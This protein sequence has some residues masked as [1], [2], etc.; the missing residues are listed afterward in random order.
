MK[1]RIKALIKEMTLEEK[2]NLTVGSSG[3]TTAAIERLNIPSIFMSD[4]PHGLGKMIDDDEFYTET[5]KATCFPTASCLASSWNIDLMYNIGEALGLECQA[6]NVDILLGPGVNMK[7]SPLGG[8]N[9]EYFSEDPILAG[10][11]GAAFVNGVQSQ[12]VGTSVKHYACNNQ[13]FER[14]SI[15]VEVNERAL[16][17]IYLKA[18]EIIV[19][20]AQPW[21]I[22][23]AYNRLAGDHCTQ[24]KKLLTEILK[25]EWKY[26][27]VV[28]SD[29]GAVKDKIQSVKSGTGLEMP[30]KSTSAE[31][32]LKGVKN[33]LIKEEEIDNSLEELLNIIFKAVSHRKEN[34]SF[35]KELHHELAKKAAAESIVLLKNKNNILPL[36]KNKVKSIAVIGELANEPRYQGAGSSKV[37]A[38]K[39]ETPLKE[40]SRICGDKVQCKYVK[41]YDINDDKINEQLIS[42]AKEA[43]KT[44][45]IALLFVGMPENF[46]SEG[47]DRSHMSLPKSHEQLINEISAVSENIIVILQ[48]GSAITMP[49]INKAKGILESYLAGQAGG[50]AVAE[51]LFG[52]INP[53]GKLAES[54]PYKLSDNPSY[55]NFPGD[56][57][58]VHYG[59]GL[60]IGYRYYD[61]KQMKILYPFGYGLSY[62]DFEIKNI[63]VNTKIIKGEKLEVSVTVKNIGTRYGK[64]VIQ[65]YISDRLCSFD[66]PIKELKGFKKTDLHPNEEKEVKFI[67]E[68]DSFSYYNPVVKD[69]VVESGEFDILIGNSS[70]NISCKETVTVQG[71]KVYKKN[72]DK[73]TLIKLW[74]EEK[75]AKE[76]IYKLCEYIPFIKDEA[77]KKGIGVIT[78]LQEIMESFSYAMFLE[79]PL[80][81]LKEYSN[82]KI[83]DEMLE[84]IFLYTR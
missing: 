82:G 71:T 65:L 39:V 66:R 68:E 36:D 35:D 45:E 75:Q 56:G 1:D 3:W 54:F 73:N 57:G 2:A 8:R 27:G 46:E 38:I 33:G 31:E 9:F 52:D 67:L 76:K 72:Y 61:K 70:N 47:Y 63:R 60:Y 22:M 43:A 83:T 10:E 5:V 59:E 48:N 24:N 23:A 79:Q 19:K 64:E 15:N 77:D 40:I 44:S 25:E 13:E 53:S 17:E 50:S 84:S 51:I 41:G 29:W 37:N 32:L 81:M 20:K 14:R 62:T 16:R 21:T 55:I 18:F 58:C 49:W 28:I 4:G 80:S 6:N 26:D 11:L 42:E 7:R 78:D 30:Y 69:W 12:G 74:L 34:I